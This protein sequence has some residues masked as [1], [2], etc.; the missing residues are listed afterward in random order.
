MFADENGISCFI[1][2]LGY[3]CFVDENGI[4]LCCTGIVTILLPQACM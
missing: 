3:V 4:F 2:E 1:D